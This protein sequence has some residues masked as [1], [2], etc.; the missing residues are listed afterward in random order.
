MNGQPLAVFLPVYFKLSTAARAELHSNCKYSSHHSPSDECQ[1]LRFTACDAIRKTERPEESFNI[2]RRLVLAGCQR[3]AP[4]ASCGI[5]HS[6]PPISQ[7][8]ECLVSKPCGSLAQ[9]QWGRKGTRGLVIRLRLPL[10]VKR[11]L[12]DNL[13]VGAYY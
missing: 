6:P 7:A 10:A 11:I 13:C 8:V 12:L 2:C 9:G 1:R 5:C 3:A 4:L